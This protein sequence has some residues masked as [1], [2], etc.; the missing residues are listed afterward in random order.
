MAMNLFT[1]AR[2]TRGASVS[3]VPLPRRLGLAMG[4]VRGRQVRRA[5]HHQ[6]K[7]ARDLQVAMPCYAMLCHLL[8]SRPGHWM[9]WGVTLPQLKRG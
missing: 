2:Q 3:A 5:E 6:A 9:V 7:S 4:D 8:K 1:G